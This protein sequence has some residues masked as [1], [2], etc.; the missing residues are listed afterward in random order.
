MK[1]PLRH[2]E[3]FATLPDWTPAEVRIPVVQPDGSWH[4]PIQSLVYPP[5]GFFPWNICDLGN[6]DSYGYYWPIG[7]EDSEPF[8]AL[9]SHDCWAIIPTASSLEKLAQLEPWQR[10]L[11]ELVDPAFETP[12]ALDFP[13]RLIIDPNSPYLLVANADWAMEQKHHDRA[14][15]LYKRAIGLVPEYT[16]AH[17]GLA[18][19]YRRTQRKP[20]AAESMLNAI[21]CPMCFWGASF[22]A[23]SNLP[24]GAVNRNDYRRKCLY[25]LRQTRGDRVSPGVRNDPL[26][27]ARESLTFASGVVLNNDFRIYEEAIEEYLQQEKRIE[28][29][30]LAMLFGEL[31]LGETTPFR[32]RNGLSVMSHRHRLAKVFER[33]GLIERR[34]LLDNTSDWSSIVR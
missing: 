31:M 12:D 16:A 18:V 15:A 8:T 11:A 4:G 22:W 19:L 9:M 17:I 7:R 2:I 14:E 32:E 1:V 34:R 25:W 3:R 5:I 13:S 26:F 10:D 23:E 20:E 27:R 30:Q 33:T 24:N 29:V 21:R 6:G 28:A